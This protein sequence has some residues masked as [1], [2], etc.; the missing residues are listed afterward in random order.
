MKS[1]SKWTQLCC[2]N[3]YVYF[4]SFRNWV[5]RL[6]RFVIQNLTQ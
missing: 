2:T 1:F 6:M 5:F 4:K 3:S